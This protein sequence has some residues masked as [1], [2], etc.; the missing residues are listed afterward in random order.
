MSYGFQPFAYCSE[1][2]C[3]AAFSALSCLHSSYYAMA[4]KWCRNLWK[5]KIMPFPN[6]YEREWHIG[7]AVTFLP[8]CPYP[9]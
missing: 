8:C 1:G 3:S 9:S 4:E 2:F 5:K 7:Y 6:I